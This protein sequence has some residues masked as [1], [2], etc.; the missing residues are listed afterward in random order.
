MRRYV[1]FPIVGVITETGIEANPALLSDAILV[2]DQRYV[3]YEAAA[4]KGLKLKDSWE[5][6]NKYMD[7]VTVVKKKAAMDVLKA[8]NSETTGGNDVISPLSRSYAYFVAVKLKDNMRASSSD[9]FVT[10]SFD[11][12]ETKNSAGVSNDDGFKFK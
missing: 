7:N 3:I 8:V 10:V 12:K 6:G 5:I 2:K 1:F 11:K 9:V 4:V